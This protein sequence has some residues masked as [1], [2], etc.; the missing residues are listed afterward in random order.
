MDNTV[1]PNYE[2]VFCEKTEKENMLDF[3]LPEYMPSISKIIKADAQPKITDKSIQNDK[4]TLECE[5]VYNI[6]YV[7]DFKNKLKSIQCKSEFTCE[8][9]CAGLSE[10]VGDDPVI[11]ASAFTNSCSCKILNNRKIALKS[12]ISVCADVLDLKYIPVM[13]TNDS[14]DENQYQYLE[15]N[16][17]SAEVMN[18]Q[19]MSRLV[20]EE[21]KVDD[22]MPDDSEII[23]AAGSVCIE[24]ATAETD[25]VKVMCS[26]EFH[27][28]YESRNENDESEYITFIK[29]IPFS[30]EYE[31]PGI[32]SSYSVLACAD[33]YSL[34]CDASID[35][36]GENRNITVSSLIKFNI[37][38][39]RNAE[40]K[41]AKDVYSTKCAVDFSRKNFT[42]EKFYAVISDNVFAE[43]KIKADMRGISDILDTNI[44]IKFFQPEIKD[45]SVC[46]PAKGVLSVLGM[47]D[48]GELR[49]EEI[50]FGM[51]ISSNELSERLG[52]DFSKYVFFCCDELCSHECVL[53]NGELIL[54]MNIIQRCAVLEKYQISVVCDISESKE[55]DENFSKQTFALYYPDKDDTVWSVAKSHRVSGDSIRTYNK[56]NGDSISDKK[57]IIIRE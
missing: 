7:S 22:S 4:V 48:S 6:V 36:Y 5:A 51:K 56:L 29:K 8:F 38:A 18:L 1:M 26:L 15:E 54:K 49:A 45:S 33:V 28:L 44:K 9:P 47:S 41:Y 13:C 11:Y 37:S 12:K 53:H 14:E 40:G 25:N 52:R 50:A 2:K 24:N 57:V 10:R 34:S 55:N 16:I 21:L 3:A 19:D 35:N 20:N 23:Y 39:F 43:E 46:I 30:C 27:C 17:E 42:L 31:W 32:D